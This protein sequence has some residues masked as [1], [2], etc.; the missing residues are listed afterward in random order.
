MLKNIYNKSKQ[1][2]I[3]NLSHQLVIDE[4]RSNPFLSKEALQKRIANELSE[5]IDLLNRRVLSGIEVLKNEISTSHPTITNLKQITYNL[6][7]LHLSQEQINDLYQIVKKL[8]NEQKMTEAGDLVCFLVQLA[9]EYAELWLAFGLT[10]KEL[11]RYESALL[12]FA[13]SSLTHFEMPMPHFLSAE[14]YREIEDKDNAA[15]S[16]QLALM[17]KNHDTAFERL[18][19]RIQTLE[20]WITK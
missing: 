2:L 15:S 17:Y 13:V 4:S 7:T 14:C 19:T 8:I 3:D 10:E 6:E 18:E 1:K 11:G 20:A 9:P 16:L 12:L 5:S